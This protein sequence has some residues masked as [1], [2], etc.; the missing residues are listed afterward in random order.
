MTWRIMRLIAP[1][2]LVL[3]LLELGPRL[4][5]YMQAGLP[6]LGLV[7]GL[8]GLVRVLFWHRQ[9]Q[10]QRIWTLRSLVVGVGLCASYA[11]FIIFALNF[12]PDI[13][14]AL[15]FLIGIVVGGLWR[16]ERW[17]LWVNLSVALLAC[18]VVCYNFVFAHASEYLVGLVCLL[19]P[20]LWLLHFMRPSVRELFR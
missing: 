5:G 8:C 17:A 1:G 11:A 16:L 6:C 9:S 7:V 14:R 10:R 20:S 12:T 18:L 15:T 13:G 2:L 4:V 3:G 19:V